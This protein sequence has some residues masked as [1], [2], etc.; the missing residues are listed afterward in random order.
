MTNLNRITLLG[1]TGREPKASST[2]GGTPKTKLSVATNKRYKDEAGVWQS[3]VE[4]HSVV[5]FGPSADYA[6]RIESGT[7]VFVEGEMSYRDYEREIEG[8]KVQWPIAEVIATSITAIQPKD[9]AERG[10]AA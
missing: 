6:A 1:N 3:G 2:A 7:L 5:V 9:K 4:W 8:V 10:A